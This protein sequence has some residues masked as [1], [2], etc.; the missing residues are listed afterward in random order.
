MSKIKGVITNNKG[1]VTKYMLI[2]KRKV[3]DSLKE[4]TQEDSKY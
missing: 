3:G 4:D 2:K 1:E